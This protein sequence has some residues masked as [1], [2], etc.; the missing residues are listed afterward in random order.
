MTG[1]SLVLIRL[2]ELPLPRHQVWLLVVEQGDAC[3]CSC[4]SFL[5][6]LRVPE[7]GMPAT[8]LASC[9][10]GRPVGLGH[11]AASPAQELQEWLSGFG[12]VAR[13]GADEFRTC[14]PWVEA[15]VGFSVCRLAN[16]RSRL[17]KQSTRLRAQRAGL[18][19]ICC[20]ARGGGHALA[21]SLQLP[22]EV[23]PALAKLVATMP[24][25]R[26]LVVVVLEPR[27]FR[28]RPV[29]SRLT[30][31]LCGSHPQVFCS[32]LLPRHMARARASLAA[33]A[34]VRVGWRGE[35]SRWTGV[36]W[37]GLCALRS[38][39]TGH[40][41]LLGEFER[42]ALPRFSPA[43]RLGLTPS[44]PGSSGL[45]RAAPRRQGA[46]SKKSFSAGLRAWPPLFRRC[47][48]CAAV[49]VAAPWTWIGLT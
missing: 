35:R 10:A 24:K 31:G 8:V 16:A 39:P 2:A 29:V 13:R 47:V 33:C 4:I 27:L 26:E 5:A 22:D 40:V 46:R 6:R 41:S 11:V 21:V 43:G 38:G 12:K 37:P 49:T 34:C 48:I 23:R 15:S 44:T 45:L 18:S 1:P 19:S 42:K 25:Y 28:Q 14:P 30:F 20:F 32:E 7:G 36:E 3:Y 9:A 17:G